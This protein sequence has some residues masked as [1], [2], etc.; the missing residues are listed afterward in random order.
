MT[1]VHTTGSLYQ[2]SEGYYTLNTFSSLTAERLYWL[3]H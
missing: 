2:N 1:A 3:S